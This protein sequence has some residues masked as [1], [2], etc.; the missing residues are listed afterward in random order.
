M[1]QIFAAFLVAFS[2]CAC[3]HHEAGEHNHDAHEEHAHSHDH[4]QHGHHHEGA[5]QVTLDQQSKLGIEC[6]KLQP[7][8][9]GQIIKCPAQILPSA[10][11]QRAVTAKASGIVI[12]HKASLVEGASVKAGET[13]FTI[14]S[15]GMA[16]N[17]MSVRFQEAQATYNLARQEYERKETL[18]REQIVSQAELAQ[19]RA[20]LESA[21]A[22]YNN[23]KANFSSKGQTL[24]SPLSGYLTSIGVQNGDYVEAGQV[25][26]TVSQNRDLY[27]RAE[28][29]P[30]YYQSLSHILGASFKVAGSNE[31]YSVEELGGG[32][33]SYGKATTAD[34]PLVPVTFRIRNNANLL[35]G[36]FVQLYIR[37]ATEQ[38]VLTLPNDGI[39]EEMGAYFAFVKVCKEEFE[40]RPITLGPT[41]GIRTVIASGLQ[42]GEQVVSKGALMVKLAQG[43]ANLD[44]H[45]GHVH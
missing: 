44:P 36:S 7:V 43:S 25:V 40:K 34:E 21:T 32:L 4:E 27:I 17:N 19:A 29:Q 13:L 28:V 39:V 37:T 11:D 26:A 30:R 3:H 22:L 5:I 2:L 18:A 1:K 9:F 12:F 42:S 8:T 38:Q 23:L 6:E 45:A 10:G 14:E 15:D 35:S 31:V 20:A 16:D 24:A 41:D 33:V